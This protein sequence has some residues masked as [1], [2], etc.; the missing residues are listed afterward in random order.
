MI[1]RRVPITLALGV[2]LLLAVPVWSPPAAHAGDARPTVP[3]AA[4]DSWQA[5]TRLRSV[6]Y[7]AD[8]NAEFL[9]QGVRVR[10]TATRP[11]LVRE[12]QTAFISQ[13]QHL[14]DRFSS[15]KDRHGYYDQAAVTIASLP[16]GVAFDFTAKAPKAVDWLRR[17]GD[18]LV[19]RLLQADI[20][21]LTASLG[22][23]KERIRGWERSPVPDSERS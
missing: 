23:L 18:R 22:L 4:W 13:G 1:D 20:R 12:I 3:P 5:L 7:F 6:L 21:H 15:L 8:F 17:R 16:D 10:V 2:A 14:Q 9:A 11:D 19:Y